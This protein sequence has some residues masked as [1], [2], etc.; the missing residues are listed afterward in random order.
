VFWNNDLRGSR[1]H[2]LRFHPD[3]TESR[4]WIGGGYMVDMNEA[5]LMTVSQTLVTAPK[6]Y[7]RALVVDGVQCWTDINDPPNAGPD[8]SSNSAAYVRFRNLTFRSDE[9]TSNASLGISD[10]GNGGAPD[11]PIPDGLE[12]WDKVNNT[13]LPAS[14]EPA[15]FPATPGSP[16]SL[17]WNIGA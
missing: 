16:L 5:R 4:A 8:F 17:N 14:A 3:G 15:W 13:F 1:F 9:L 11:V 6:G 2:K 12:N 10:G 7:M